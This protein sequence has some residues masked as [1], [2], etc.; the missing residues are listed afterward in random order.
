MVLLISTVGCQPSSTSGPNVPTAPTASPANSGLP[1]ATPTP[2][3]SATALPANSGLPGQPD[4]TPPTVSF[5]SPINAELGIAV[6]RKIVA[7]FSEVMDPASLSESTF[8]VTAPGPV[9]VSGKVTYIGSVATFTP[10]SNLAVS[11]SY[12]ATISTKAQDL[13]GNA[14]A[15]K[16][17]W[18]FTT[19][20]SRDTTAPSESYSNPANGAT[21][22]ATSG[23]LG[24]TFS[25][26]MDPATV[27][28]DTF[29]LREQPGSKP[30]AGTVTYIGNIVSF[31]PKESLKPNTSYTA[32]LTTGAKDLAGNPFA[33]DK[34]WTFITGASDGAG[35]GSTGGGGGGGSS[36]GG[37]TA[38][39]SGNA[40]TT[41]PTLSASNPVNAAL[42]VF[43]NGKLAVTFSEVMDASSLNSTTFSLVGPGQTPVLGSVTYAGTTATFTPAAN[44]AANTQFT[45]TITNGVKDLSGNALAANQTWTFT[46]GSAIDTTAPTVNLSTPANA[47]TGVAVNSAVSSTFSEAMNALTISAN[48]F[49]L[50]GP[51]AT[52]VSGAVTYVGNIATFT[53][54][55]NLAANTLYTATVNMGVL[56]LAGNPLAVNKVW[57]FTTGTTPD[58]TAPLVNASNPANLGTSVLTT[59]LNTATFNEPMNPLTLTTATFTLT[60]P[61]QVPVPGTVSYLGNVATFTPTTELARKTLYTATV[62]TG[63]QDLAGNPLAANKV[64][65]FTTALGPAAVNLRTAADFAVLS[66]SGISSVPGSVITGD[67]GVSPIALIAIT[68]FSEVLDASTT[69]A[70]STQ[71]TGRIYAANLTAPTPTK[72]TTAIG[73]LATAYTDA[74][75]RTL[76]DFSELG[77]GQ[78]G[79]LTLVPGLYKWGTNVLVSTDVTLNG[80][81]NDIWIFQIS[82][83][84]NQASD[85][86]VI[87]TGGAQAKNV[88]WQIAGDV[89]IG[90]RAHFEGIIMCETEINLDSDASVNGRLLANTAVNLIKN[91]VTQP[92]S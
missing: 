27:N 18:V 73:D 45:A 58:T 90:A 28:T 16:K 78:M 39:G 1:S 76:P 24:L 17:S 37:S 75:G 26:V 46:T 80:G 50:T 4:K 38:G 53:P 72:M 52:P 48:S 33:A 7:T 47:A 20:A 12:T 14:I 6:N 25:E 3:A 67:I 42:N 81:P 60:G 55:N 56:D 49:Q 13:A 44:L 41:P 11:T 40:D 64:W 69:F 68:G 79:G 88:F 54:T 74:A 30:V 85:K 15:L 19:N 62:T 82:G 66:K 2:G 10:T 91:T 21:N 77:A 8:T 89:S 36:G 61:G 70:T 29:L 31:N 43:T 9:S 51:G 84:V 87:L 57:T 35:S 34:T 5:T 22:V 63:A 83:G 71:V 86:R 59:S 23:N 92:A 32:T 65:T